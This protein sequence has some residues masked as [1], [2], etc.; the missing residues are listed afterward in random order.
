[1]VSLQW[2][3]RRVLAHFSYLLQSPRV[4]RNVEH[5]RWLDSFTPRYFALIM[6]FMAQLEWNAENLVG[7]FHARIVVI[8]R[9]GGLAAFTAADLGCMV[10]ALKKQP[11][12]PG[13]DDVV[14]ALAV[15]ATRK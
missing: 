9:E 4:Y 12:G 14:M 7:G 11:R 3:S 5:Q 2:P 6:N 1:M 13:K 10:N 15:D 8:S